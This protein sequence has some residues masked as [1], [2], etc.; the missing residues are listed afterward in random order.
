MLGEKGE[1]W[2]NFP[3]NDGAVPHTRVVY[4]KAEHYLRDHGPLLDRIGKTNGKYLAVME[5]GQPASWEGRALHVNSLHDP[6]NSYTLGQLPE[7]WTI[8]V[9][10][11]AP[12][13]GQSGG[14]IQVRVLDDEGNARS[15]VDL[16]RKGVL[17]T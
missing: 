2:F 1:H 14:S 6:Y 9:S 8:E 11:V 4:T 15:V 10:E 16:I 5:N 12:G 3:L 7:E 13:V 17:R